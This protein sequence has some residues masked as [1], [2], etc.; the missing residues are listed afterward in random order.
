MSSQIDSSGDYHATLFTVGPTGKVNQTDLRNLG[1]NDSSAYGINASGQIVGVSN[2]SVSDSNNIPQHA[3]LF[4]VS[5]NGTV[6]QTNL[7]TSAGD[8]CFANGINDAGQIVGS[9]TATDGTTFATLFLGSSTTQYLGRLG[10][11]FSS[12]YSIN[13]AGQA[14]GYSTTNTGA[15]YHATLFSVSG[16]NINQPVDLGTL[17]GGNESFAYGI[18]AAGQVVGLSTTSSGFE[19]ATLF[20][21]SNGK[22]SQTDLGTLPRDTYSA[23]YAIKSTG[24]IVGNS[25]S[26]NGFLY[27]ATGGMKSLVSLLTNSS[28]VYGF[29]LPSPGNRGSGGAPGGY[30]NDWGQIVGYGQLA[31]T[32]GQLDAVL[33]NP[34]TPNTTT[35]TS[36][37]APATQDSKPVAGMSYSKVP[38]LTNAQAGSNGTAVSLLDGIAGANRDVTETFDAPVHFGLQPLA[39][40]TVNVHGTGGDTFVLDLSCNVTL[41]STLLGGAANARLDW[42]D[43]SDNTWKLAVAGD[44]GGTAIFVGNRPYNPATDFQL[45]LYG[46]DTAD[47]VVWAVINHNSDFGVS[48]MNIVPETIRVRTSRLDGGRICS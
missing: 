10:G 40:D 18:N 2:L 42:L 29:G 5:P 7:G 19:H 15:P 26:G 31:Q 22:A 43:P 46:V 1:G 24:Q 30:I 11:Q 17:P 23:A 12:A 44:T 14:A 25:G 36:L 21:D 48:D 13:S 41:A 16:G 32:G 37:S 3:T 39:S 34:T 45:G 33:L 9:S 38:V 8:G 47:G 27:T 20:S 4:S 35:V 6:S 28:D